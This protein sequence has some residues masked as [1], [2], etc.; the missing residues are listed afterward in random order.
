MRLLVTLKIP[1]IVVKRM[2]QFKSVYFP[3]GFHKIE[4]HI[5]LKPPFDLA[6]DFSAIVGAFQNL[7]KLFR[8]FSLA[9]HGVGTFSDRILFFTFD[10]PAELTKLE[11]EV[12]HLVDGSFKRTQPL[13]KERTSTG[14]Y[15]PHATISVA[16][17]EKIARY[18]TE[19]EE[20]FHGLDFLVDGIVLYSWKRGRWISEKEILFG[21]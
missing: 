3:A 5:T 4:S 17:A 11:R 2:D 8:P 14:A 7:L 21:T 19:I 9:A 13:R 10:C 16:S 20:A 1:R 18:R 15:M 6:G 12:S